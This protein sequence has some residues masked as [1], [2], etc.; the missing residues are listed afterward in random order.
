[1]AL[2][3]SFRDAFE[4]CPICGGELVEKKVEKLLRGGTDTASLEVDALVCL[5]CGERLYP[6][7]TVRRFEHIRSDLACG[8]T[9]ELEP[10]GKAYRAS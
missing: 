9:E 1:M 3:Q 5:H 7:D 4:L 8:S 6:Q 2:Q 10:V